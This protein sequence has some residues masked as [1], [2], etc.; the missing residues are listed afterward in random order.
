QLLPGS[1]PHAAG[2][3]QAVGRPG[4]RVPR[5]DRR[6][7]AALMDGRSA[8][9]AQAGDAVAEVVLLCRVP[10]A[11]QRR[12]VVGARQVRSAGELV[13]VGEDRQAT[14]VLAEVLVVGQPFDDR[15]A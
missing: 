14:M 8:S 3:A 13:Q 11:L 12:E 4:A 2:G 15:D 6:R 10:G 1:A 9:L 7:A 5:R